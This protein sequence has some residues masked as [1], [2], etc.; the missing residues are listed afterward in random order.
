MRGWMAIGLVA[1]A[2]ALGACS[3]VGTPASASHG[4]KPA[5]VESISGSDV[6]KVKLTERAAQRLGVQTVVVAA[7]TKAPT[8][9]PA[10]LLVPYSAVL[11][12]PDGS[13][14]VFT[15]PEPRTYVRA[16]VVVVTV[17]GAKG[18][19][20]YLS[21]GPPVGTTIVSTGVIELW[22]TELGVGAQK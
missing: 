16:K 3:S 12:Q 10:S 1:V 21:E 4:E 2:M 19:E 7:A 18:T 13:T 22:G 6:K 20:A 14:W 15:V 5:S 17:G 9:A 8:G 11:Y